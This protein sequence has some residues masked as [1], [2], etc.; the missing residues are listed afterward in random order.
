MAKPAQK[1]EPQEELVNVRRRQ[2]RAKKTREKILAAALTEFAT[3]GFEGTTTRSIAERAKIPHGLVVYHFE[4]KLNV[5]QAVI[6]NALIDFH[7]EIERTYRELK[8]S[9]SEILLRA[10]HRAFILVSARK[11]ELNWLF[12]HEVAGQSERLS[13][14]LDQVQGSDIEQTLNLIR[15]LQAAGKYIE[16]DPAHLHFLFIGAASRVFAL[17]PEIEYRIGVSPFD[18]SFV[19]RHIELCARLFFRDGPS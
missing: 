17:A 6:E 13:W 15:E 1:E 7:E 9:D 8:G 14:L 16:G 12:S 10:Y 4:T 3:L 2:G 11:P 5:W 19:E 18:E